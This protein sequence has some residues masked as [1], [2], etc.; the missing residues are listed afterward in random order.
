MKNKDIAGILSDHDAG[1][2]PMNREGERW[3]GGASHGTTVL[4]NPQPGWCRAAE[5]TAHQKGPAA[6]RNHPA[7]PHRA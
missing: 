3:G 2:T 7:L 1:L 4:R 5:Q 6:R